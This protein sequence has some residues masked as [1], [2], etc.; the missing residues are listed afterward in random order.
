[1]N[2]I[3]TKSTLLLACGF[4]LAALPGAF[5]AHTPEHAKGSQ[6]A[7][8]KAM[9]TDGDGFV[10]RAEHAASGKQMFTDADTDH[11]G[12]VTLAEMTAACDKMKG[13]MPAKDAMSPAEMIKMHDQN[14]DGQ[15]SADEQAAACDMMFAKMD[16]NNDGKLSQA[17]CKAGHKMMKQGK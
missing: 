8:F 4:A 6:E 1:M 10:S 2:Q 7:M 15:V 5:A 17:E 11:N 16:T 14:G 9:D 12:T 13:D 3:K